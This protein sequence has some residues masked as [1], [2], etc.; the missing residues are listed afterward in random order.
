VN[1]LKELST[2]NI[3]GWTWRFK[4]GTKL[5]EELLADD[6]AKKRLVKKNDLR[7][8]HYLE[9]TDG[10]AYYLKSFKADSFVEKLKA[11]A[12]PK[13]RSEYESFLALEKKSVPCVEYVGWA[14]KGNNSLLLSRGMPS[15]ENAL[16]FWF[17]KAVHD[18][19]LK[20]RFLKELAAFLKS[21][22]SA[23][24]F[25]PDFHLGNLLVNPETCEFAIVDPYGIKETPELSAVQRFEMKRI[26]GALRA[27]LDL[28]EAVDLILDS[29]LSPDPCDAEK[30]WSRIVEAEAAEMRKLWSKRK[31]QI[32]SGNSKYCRE[33]I[34]NGEK[35]MIRNDI[36]GKPMA[37]ENDI[38]G[39]SDFNEKFDRKDFSAEEAEK[40]WLASFRLQFH[41]LLHIRPALLHC[42]KEGKSSLYFEKPEGDSVNGAVSFERRAGEEGF[43][44]DGDNEFI[45]K[46]GNVFLKDISAMAGRILLWLFIFL[47]VFAPEASAKLG[48]RINNSV[49]AEKG[50]YVVTDGA[51]IFP[52]KL[53]GFAKFRGIEYGNEKLGVSVRYMKGNTKADVYIY[54]MGMNKVPTGGRSSLMMKCFSRAVNDIFLAEK[55]GFYQNV[56]VLFRKEITVKTGIGAL[57]F[58]CAGLSYKEKHIPRFSYLLLSG[59]DNNFI[60]IRFTF[61]ENEKKTGAGEKSLKEFLSG[62][63]SIL[64]GSLSKE[65]VKEAI[66]IFDKEPLSD[67][68]K[69]ALAII[70][71]FAEG[72]KDVMI[73][74][75][76]EVA[77]WVCDKNSAKHN[78]SL[79]GAF[80][81]GNLKSQLESGK[82]ES[83]PYSGLLETFRIYKLIKEKDKKFNS[84]EIDKLMKLKAENKLKDFLKKENSKTPEKE[85][86]KNLKAPK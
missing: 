55:K 34:I 83:D 35:W 47:F 68:G 18:E 23:G 66:S 79:I 7:E 61:H 3:A 56:E 65:T 40:I 74:I 6:S 51:I 13:A 86:E 26:L 42:G 85:T 33:K 53:G 48:D 32:L 43:H 8:V 73:V 84:P 81:A 58:L 11:L 21:F 60:K 70:I 45:Q 1:D 37:D 12:S 27:E 14:S 46:E 52:Q 15:S 62:L 10:A 41:R 24:L 9:G 38:C 20:K 44:M 31:T 80:I 59:Y 19:D 82:K 2:K 36:T 39:N 28:R 22:F 78:S 54:N 67:E 76:P 63:G 25:H 71:L 64:R 30:L 77:P 75:S 72:S 29:G 50:P 5:P 49:D 16:S 57:G 4:A 69:K 17:G